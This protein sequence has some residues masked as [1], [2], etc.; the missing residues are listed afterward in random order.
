M[1]WH[2]WSAV[3]EVRTWQVMRYKD[4]ERETERKSRQM[5]AVLN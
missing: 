3:E 4:L 2:I 1:D 5:T